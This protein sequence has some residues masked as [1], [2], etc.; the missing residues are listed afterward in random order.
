MSY[1]QKDNTGSLFK[2][3]RKEKDTHPD[4]TGS[5]TVDGVAYWISAWSK[6]D[7]NGNHYQSLSVRRK[8]QTM[9]AANTDGQRVMPRKRDELYDES[10][11]F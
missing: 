11:P 10:I 2:N 7:R 5:I 6:Q 1:E 4:A 9:P 8:E 3:Q